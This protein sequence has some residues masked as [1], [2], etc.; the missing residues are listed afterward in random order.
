MPVLCPPDRERRQKRII[1]V[2]GTCV[3]LSAS[4]PS[5]G[6]RFVEVTEMRSGKEYAYF[7]DKLSDYCPFAEKIGAVR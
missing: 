1:T 6:R 7:T 3:L 4:E 2:N 5:T